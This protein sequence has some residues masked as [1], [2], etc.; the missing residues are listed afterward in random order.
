MEGKKLYNVKRGAWHLVVLSRDA[1]ILLVE[2]C[3]TGAGN[4]SYVP[5]SMELRKMIVETAA[6]ELPNWWG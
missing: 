3:D 2:N 5:L 4:S 1:S 6:R